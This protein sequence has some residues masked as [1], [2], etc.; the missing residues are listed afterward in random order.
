MMPTLRLN[1]VPHVCYSVHKKSVISL[2]SVF[3]GDDTFF[4]G[5]LPAFT[6]TVE[7]KAVWVHS[8]ELLLADDGTQ[9]LGG[10][11]IC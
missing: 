9:A 2:I 4:V 1:N 8:V 7:G 6:C 3:T 11:A 5:L 10:L